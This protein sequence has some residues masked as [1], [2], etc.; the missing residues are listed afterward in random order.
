MAYQSLLIAAALLGMLLSGV[1]AWK[2][3]RA[4][5]YGVDAWNIHEGSCKFGWLDRNVMTGW[6]IAAISDRAPDIQGSCGKCKEVRCKPGGFSDGY[7]QYIDRT[8]ACYNNYQSVVVMVTD[9]C[10]CVY[11]GNYASN[12]RWCCMDMYH[13]DLS[14]WAYERLAQK[15]WGVIGVEWRDVSCKYKPKSPA[16]LPWWSKP[17]PAP[18]WYKQPYGWSKN[19]DKRIAMSLGKEQFPHNGKK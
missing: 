18:Y 7:G 2:A 3:G 8:T 4:T 12:K 14:V 1:D 16:K 17:T 6:N 15:K 9:R 19:M 10:D 11:P 13:L 5:F